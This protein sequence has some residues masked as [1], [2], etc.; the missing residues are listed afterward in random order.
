VL[1]DEKYFQGSFDFLPIV[2]GIARSQS[3]AKT[4]LSIRTKSGWHGFTR[5]M[6]A[7]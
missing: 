7:C 2:S 5:P 4:L 1:T 6:P 3:C